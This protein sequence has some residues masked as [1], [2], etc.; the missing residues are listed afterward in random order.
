MAAGSKTA[1]RDRTARPRRSELSVP[2]SSGRF[3]A[4]AAAGAADA[5]GL[6]LEDGV[7]EDRKD[8]VDGVERA[9]GGAPASPRWW[10][11]RRA[12]RGWTRSPAP[13]PGWKR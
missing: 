4:K 12:S 5:V 3:F 8:A 1:E 2:A 7:A 9:H 11:R 10:K 6:D 13:T